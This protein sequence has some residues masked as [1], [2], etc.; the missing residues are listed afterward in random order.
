MQPCNKCSR[1]DQFPYS[2]MNDTCF[3]VA[4]LTFEELRRHGKPRATLVVSYSSL[5]YIKGMPRFDSR[6]PFPSLSSTL[7]GE[8]ESSW[9]ILASHSASYQSSQLVSLFSTFFSFLSFPFLSITV[10]LGREEMDEFKYLVDTPEGLSGF[11]RAYEILMM[12][13]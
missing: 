4:R 6:F 11:R 7:L 8:K 13:G 5:P 12:L 9:H 10:C 2:L 3:L 1:R